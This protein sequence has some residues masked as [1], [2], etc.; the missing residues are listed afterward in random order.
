MEKR[1]KMQDS[2]MCIKFWEDFGAF[3]PTIG[4]LGAV[5]GLIQ[6]MQN[7]DKPELI[8]AHIALAFT[9]TLY[10]VGS[11]NI[12]FVPLSK[13]LRRKAQ[14]EAKARDMVIAGVD[15]LLTGLNPK[16][17]KED[18]NIFMVEGAA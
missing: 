10:G 1:V 6:A 13:K 12:I 17:I 4:I 18:L 11:A 16:I 3:A 5:L 15:G 2:G 8:G 9:A 14:L 7:I